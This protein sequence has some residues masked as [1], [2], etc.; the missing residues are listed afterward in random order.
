MIDHYIELFLLLNLK[1]NLLIILIFWQNLSLQSIYIAHTER[2]LDEFIHFKW[3]TA[4]SIHRD[5]F[6][7]Y[8]KNSY[9]F[10]RN[11]LHELIHTQ[12]QTVNMNLYTFSSNWLHELIHIQSQTAIW[13]HNLQREIYLQTLYNS[14][15]FHHIRWHMIVI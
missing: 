11:Q 3:Q 9:T 15:S 7:N 14:K 8:H 1:L 6:A 5:K 13:I 4:I 12:S 2:L 10:S